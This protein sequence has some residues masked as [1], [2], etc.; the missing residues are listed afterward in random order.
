MTWAP[1]NILDFG[2]HKGHRLSDVYKF[3][4]DYLEW[5]VTYIEDFIIDIE[6]FSKLPKPT[7]Y[8]KYYPVKIG[9]FEGKSFKPSESDIPH[10][11]QALKNGEVIKE[12]DYKFPSHIVEINEQKKIGEYD[13]PEWTPIDKKLLDVNELIKK[14]VPADEDLICLTCGGSK[15]TGCLVGRTD[16]NKFDFWRRK[17]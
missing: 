3:C 13:V 15:K 5:A 8:K 4:P 12:I 17:T 1:D 11:Y 9:T 2:K 10:G 6:A 7:P 14:E 16:C